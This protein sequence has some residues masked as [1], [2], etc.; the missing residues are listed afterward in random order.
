MT[1]IEVMW[2]LADSARVLVTHQRQYLPQCDL[3]L[4][5]RDGRPHAYGTPAQLAPLCLPELHVIAGV[6][7]TKDC[8]STLVYYRPFLLHHNSDRGRSLLLN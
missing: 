7:L 3:I 5:L 2:W 8:N 6:T 1:E 4:V